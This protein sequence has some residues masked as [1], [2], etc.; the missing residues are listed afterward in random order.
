MG[1]F[2]F[3]TILLIIIILFDSVCVI[4]IR[5]TIQWWI[6]A[7]KIVLSLLFLNMAGVIW[8]FFFHSFYFFYFFFV[9]FFPFILSAT[10]ITDYYGLKIEYIRL[11]DFCWVTSS[12]LHISQR[13]QYDIE[14]T[15]GWHKHV[16]LDFILLIM[17]S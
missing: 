8:R 11:F 14:Y 5:P 15:Y 17:M 13:L 7:E 1:F 4:R 10:M 6:N 16:L 12:S 9:S 2:R 3:G